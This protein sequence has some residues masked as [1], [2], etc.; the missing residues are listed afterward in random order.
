MLMNRLP[1]LVVELS[2][3][4]LQLSK[5][6]FECHFCPEAGQ[7]SSLACISSFYSSWSNKNNYYFP[8]HL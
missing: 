4:E 3:L 6:M 1:G 2:S 8:L 7:G 5:V